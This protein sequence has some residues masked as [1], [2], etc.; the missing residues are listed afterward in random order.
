MLTSQNRS[1]DL[2]MLEL[3]NAKE[4]DDEEWARLFHTADARFMFR[5]VQFLRGSKLA[6]IE[7]SWDGEDHRS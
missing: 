4:R 6:I 3:F 7:A 2:V 1:F 5:G